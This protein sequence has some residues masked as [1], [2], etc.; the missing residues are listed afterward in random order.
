MKIGRIN[1]TVIPPG[2]HGGARP[3]AGR[4]PLPAGE[5]V[6]TFSICLPPLLIAKLDQLREGKLNAKGKKM[7]RSERIAHWIKGA[8]V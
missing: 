1:S 3:G 8:K 2:Q 7:S 4:K 6:E 5:K